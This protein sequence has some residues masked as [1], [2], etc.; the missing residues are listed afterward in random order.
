MY[1]L[2]IHFEYLGSHPVIVL[3]ISFAQLYSLDHRIH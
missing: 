1:D 3:K 2:Y